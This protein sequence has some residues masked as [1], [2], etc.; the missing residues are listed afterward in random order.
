MK[1]VIAAIFLAACT[2]LTGDIEINIQGNPDINLNKYKTYAWADS[3][4][5]VFDPIGQWEKPTLDTD[6][7]VRFVINRELN[8][9]GLYEVGHDPDLLIAFAAGVNTT[10]LKLKEDPEQGNKVLSNIPQAALVITL[11]DTQIGYP[12][13]SGYAIGTVQEQQPI[14]NIRARIDYAVTRIFSTFN[15]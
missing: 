5:V 15:K 8:K 3:A 10:V 4:Q 1:I 9:R 7:E 6:E 12:V 13:W 2:S 14:E 11:I